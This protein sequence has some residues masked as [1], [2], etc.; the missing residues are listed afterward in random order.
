MDFR[1]SRRLFSQSLVQIVVP[2]PICLAY[3]GW[4]TYM[5]IR[6]VATLGSVA[7]VCDRRISPLP[8][9][10]SSERRYSKFPSQTYILMY[11]ITQSCVFPG[12]EPRFFIGPARRPEGWLLP[13]EFADRRL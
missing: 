2:N 13:I 12:V 6:K 11:R 1:G 4:L 8:V 10:A 3:G 5:H 9:R 7:P